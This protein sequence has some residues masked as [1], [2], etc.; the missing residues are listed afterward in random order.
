MRLTRY[1]EYSLRILLYLGLR[2]DRLCSIAEIAAAYR[3]SESHLTKVVQ[4]LGRQGFID[5]QRGRGGGLR[6]ARPP[7]AISLAEVVRLNESGLKNPDCSDCPLVPAC[8]L[9]GILNQALRAFV[10]VFE[11]Y[12]LSDILGP[13]DRLLALLDDS[14]ARPV[15]SA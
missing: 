11:D 6:L 12:T 8:K 14:L 5:T 13:G 2:Q 9:T 1:T 10:Q 3:I 4:A 15:V 7:E